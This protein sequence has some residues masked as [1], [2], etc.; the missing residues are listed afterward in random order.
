MRYVLGIAAVA[1]ALGVARLLHVAFHEQFETLTVF[2]LAVALVGWFLSIGP[3]IAAVVF[4]TLALDYFCIPPISSVSIDT[5]MPLA[6]RLGFLLVF[7]VVAS[8]LR[9][10][11]QTAQTAAEHQEARIAQIAAQVAQ[12]EAER[13][14]ALAGLALELRTATGLIQLTA[15]TVSPPLA[16]PTET[17]SIGVIYHATDQLSRVATQLGDMARPT[18]ETD[19]LLKPFLD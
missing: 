15:D 8:T 4:A 18:A 2:S 14:M 19:L 7:V 3:G 1:V 13:G 9:S 11:L 17:S 16:R 12:G 6:I 10:R 5:A